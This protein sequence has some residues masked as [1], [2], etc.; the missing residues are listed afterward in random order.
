MSQ[1]DMMS[2]FARE[3]HKGSIHY[4]ALVLSTVALGATVSIVASHRRSIA[5][6]DGGRDTEAYPPAPG[7]TKDLVYTYLMETKRAN[8]LSDSQSLSESSVS[9]IVT[10]IHM[11]MAFEWLKDH[12]AIIRVSLDQVAD[13][14]SLVCILHGS[15]RFSLI[16]C[17]QVSSRKITCP[18]CPQGFCASPT[19]PPSR[20]AVAVDHRLSEFPPIDRNVRSPHHT[21]WQNPT[22]IAGPLKHHRVLP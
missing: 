12:E 11:F 8:S 13:L 10:C 3:E 19:S 18:P 6:S 21:R 1:S 7:L 9:G 5:K 14:L 15:S 20:P 16:I 4:R 17:P 22:P 2:A